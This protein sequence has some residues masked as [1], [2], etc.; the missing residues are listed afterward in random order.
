MITAI[1]A[2]ESE[3]EI[4][5]KNATVTAEKTLLGKKT[6][7]GEFHGKKFAL[8]ICGVGKV[9]AALFANAAS[10]VTIKKIGTTGSATIREILDVVGK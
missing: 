8:V 3:A 9:N 2:M 1:I 6:Y 10:A 7:E 4:L 5:L